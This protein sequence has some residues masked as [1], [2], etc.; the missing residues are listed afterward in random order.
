MGLYVVNFDAVSIGTA[1]Q[2]LFAIKAGANVTC[3]L[4]WI[5]LDST[6]T[7]AAALRMR[8]RRAT[9]TV[10]LGTGTSYTPN[11]L[12]ELD[13]ACLSTAKTNVR[14]QSTTSGSFVDI[15]FFQW[16]TVLPFDY[17]PTPETRPRCKAAGG[18]ILDLPTTITAATCSGFMVFEETV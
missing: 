16:D 11:P 5:H 6:N 8:L 9:A 14:T 15:G 17:M 12:N 2:D 13:Q 18:L 1:V 7:A 10:T 3:I 4:H